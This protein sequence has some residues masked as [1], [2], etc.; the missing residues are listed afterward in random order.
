MKTKRK[1]RKHITWILVF[2]EIILSV[3]TGV[4]LFSDFELSTPILTLL[5]YY[6]IAIVAFILAKIN[7]SILMDFGNKEVIN[8]VNKVIKKVSNVNA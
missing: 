3:I 1:L 7:Y 8:K 4:I 6:F 5:K 2:F